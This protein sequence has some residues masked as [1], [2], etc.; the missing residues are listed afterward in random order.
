M[1]ENGADDS[2]DPSVNCKVTASLKSKKKKEKYHYAEF[3][4]NLRFFM[5]KGKNIYTNTSSFIFK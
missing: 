5:Y 2:S 1:V 4:V 3:M